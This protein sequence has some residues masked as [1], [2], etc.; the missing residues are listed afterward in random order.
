MG[1]PPQA[2]LSRHRMARRVCRG[3]P[4]FLRLHLGAQMSSTACCQPLT[5]VIQLSYSQITGEL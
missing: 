3:R 5:L 2:A 1:K 4:S